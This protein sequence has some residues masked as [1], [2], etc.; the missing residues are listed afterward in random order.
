[1]FYLSIG[2]AIQ[3]TTESKCQMTNLGGTTV[4]FCDGSVYE[5]G[6]GKDWLGFVRL[7][8]ERA[9]PSRVHFASILVETRNGNGLL[10][11]LLRAGHGFYFKRREWPLFKPYM[12]SRY[13]NWGSC[14]KVRTLILLICSDRDSMTRVDN[15]FMYRPKQ[16]WKV[17]LHGPRRSWFDML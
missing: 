10:V 4:Q 7:K 12:F 1:M 5:N 8:I 2:V 15:F 6:C 13:G 3:H 14:F 16:D 9:M 17:L 11:F